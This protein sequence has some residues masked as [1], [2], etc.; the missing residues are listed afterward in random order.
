MSE[1]KIQPRLVSG[2]QDYSPEQMIAK[3]KMLAT[4]AEVYEMFGFEPLDTATVHTRKVLY[5]ELEG[6]DQTGGIYEVVNTRISEG[7]LKQRT[8]LRYD[9]TVSLARYVAANLADLPRPFKR[10]QVGNVFRPEKTQAGRYCE[11]AQCDADIMFSSSMMADAEIVNLLFT[12]MVR[13]GI[14]DFYIDLNNRKISDG[15]PV[16]AGFDSELLWPVLRILDKQ[17]K[18]GSENVKALLSKDPKKKK[19]ALP[20]GEGLGLSSAVVARIMNFVG[21]AGSNEE[22]LDQMA[23]MMQG[24]AVAEEGIAELKE[25]ISYL[26]AMG[27]TD[28]VVRITPGMVRGLEYYTGPVF[29]TYLSEIPE[30]GSVFSGGRF[31]GLVGRFVDAHVPA[32]GASVGVDRLLAALDKLDQ[33]KKRNSVVEVMIM[34]LDQEKVPFYL[35]L[36]SDLRNKALLNVMVYMGEDRSFKAQFARA[37]SQDIPLVLIPAE[38][39]LADNKVAVKNLVTRKQELVS[40]DD[41]LELAASVREMLSEIERKSV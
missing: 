29:E 18:I 1:K 6:T 35:E 38:R 8:A 2:F 10:W 41:R 17:E 25:I 12:V 4:I 40:L 27:V 9:L 19:E 28:G 5:G 30:F 24:I 39:E 11:F 13:L 20:E 32:V 26:P 7:E 23:E 37:V 3:R 21:L 36:A 31:D 34:C 14:E 33:L 16:Y 15:L 22:I